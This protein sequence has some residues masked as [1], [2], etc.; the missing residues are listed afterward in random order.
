MPETLKTITLN[1]FCIF[2]VAMA[3]QNG[4][5]V[6]KRWRYELRM[7]QA[8]F[9]EGFLTEK[10]SFPLVWSNSH[11]PRCVSILFPAMTNLRS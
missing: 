1:H 5:K 8:Q 3:K 2:G 11:D 6:S 7:L 4:Q 9:H 10:V